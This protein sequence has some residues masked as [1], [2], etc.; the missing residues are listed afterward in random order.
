MYAPKPAI[1]L[2]P[3]IPSKTTKYARAR[4]V[5]HSESR[6]M[7]SKFPLIFHDNNVT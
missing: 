4:A 6:K 2:V 7:F 3:E 1:F 5:E